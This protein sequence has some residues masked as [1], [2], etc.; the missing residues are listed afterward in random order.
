MTPTPAETLIPSKPSTS[1][2]DVILE[3]I[4]RL[5][6]PEWLVYASL[7]TVGAA[8]I[9]FA[10]WSS[11]ELVRGQWSALHALLAFWAVFPLAFID[12]LDRVA[13]RAMAR[14]RPSLPADDA[15]VERL[16][17]S[18][19][20]MPAAQTLAAG[21]IGVGVL[22][23]ARVTTPGLF[24]AAQTTGLSEAMWLALLSLNFALVSC[25]IYHT[26]RQLSLVSRVYAG[27]REVNLFHMDPLYAFSHLTAQSGAGW[28]LAVYLSVLGFPQMLGSPVSA[29]LA[30][31]MLA[32][33]LAAF[34]WPLWGIHVR[35][36]EAK[37]AFLGEAG[38]RAQA[39]VRRIYERQDHGDS[40]S[41]SRL[42]TPVATF[43]TIRDEVASL[44]TW[45]WGPGTLTGFLSALLLPIAIWGLQL[46]LS[47]VLGL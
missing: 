37:N 16:R 11:G 38:R 28:G 4:R 24:R 18:L 19:T 7:V 35:I 34:I 2:I 45:P 10:A 29:A 41:V 33:A 12:Y 14:I 23:F 25:A 20:T 13:E 21:A 26:V 22:W 6:V 15:E 27:I 9:H 1:W 42:A 40:E 5:P 3:G 31:M 47:R 36:R 43:L 44:P 30:G 46:L 8:L 32:L 39:A 17:R